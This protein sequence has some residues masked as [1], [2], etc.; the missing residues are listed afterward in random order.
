[1]RRVSFALGLGS[2]LLVTMAGCAAEPD[3][4][5]AALASPVSAE[6]ID[7]RCSRLA[8][9]HVA[10]A[11]WD[12]EEGGCVVRACEDGWANDRSIPNDAVHYR[13][14]ADAAKDGCETSIALPLAR[15][16]YPKAVA[17]DSGWGRDA[18][19]IYRGAGDVEIRVKIAERN[20]LPKDMKVQVSL[21]HDSA[22][23]YDLDVSF[24][25]DCR[26]P[27]GRGGRRP[28]GTAFGGAPYVRTSEEVNLFWPDRVAK[29]DDAELTIRVHYAGG[30]APNSDGSFTLFV[31]SVDYHAGIDWERD[32]EDPFDDPFRPSLACTL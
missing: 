2:V 29:G 26:D 23:R 10:S 22:V 15:A 5:A 14:A 8:A 4:G 18:K 3:D 31:G 13:S 12:D 16:T 32:P 28:G 17:G 6:R 19:A 9:M 20:Y 11:A 25:G 7:A 21:W 27:E 1:M 24:P 30:G